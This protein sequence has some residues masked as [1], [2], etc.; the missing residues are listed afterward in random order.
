MLVAADEPML[1][2]GGEEHRGGVGASGLS[3]LF[4]I[5]ECHSE[6]ISS[7]SMCTARHEASRR[8]SRTHSARCVGVSARMTNFIPSA[9]VISKAWPSAAAVGGEADVDAELLALVRSVTERMCSHSTTASGAALNALAARSCS[10]KAKA[11]SCSTQYTRRHDA[12]EPSRA[13]EA[14]GAS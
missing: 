14:A 2:R 8:I 6:E 4:T 10:K 11:E 12:G 3:A 5:T 1:H 9:R 7:C 13:F